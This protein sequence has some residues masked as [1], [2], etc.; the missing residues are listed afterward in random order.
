MTGAG[1]GA[2]GTTG[3]STGGTAATAAPAGATDTMSTAAG[4]VPVLDELN[5]DTLLNKHTGIYYSRLAGTDSAVD[6][7]I[8]ETD[9]VANKGEPQE[10]VT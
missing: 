9:A 2:T 4:Y 3:S 7:E 10:E 1:A 5:F 6:N 8:N